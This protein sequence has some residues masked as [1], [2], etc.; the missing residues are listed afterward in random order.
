MSPSGLIG[1]VQ[2]S[3]HSATLLG[4]QLISR[5]DGLFVLQSL[6]HEWIL[7]GPLILSNHGTIFG[8]TSEI[9]F[10]PGEFLALFGSTKICFAEASKGY[11]GPPYPAFFGAQEGLTKSSFYRMS[12]RDSQSLTQ[13]QYRSV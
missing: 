3:Q 10:A 8:P 2:C 5:L 4:D 7:N 12:C 6:P 13:R 9:V 11:D 1:L